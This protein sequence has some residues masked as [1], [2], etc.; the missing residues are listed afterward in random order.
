MRSIGEGW[1]SLETPPPDLAHHLPMKGRVETSY[2]PK[3]YFSFRP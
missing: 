2:P 3:R 1:G